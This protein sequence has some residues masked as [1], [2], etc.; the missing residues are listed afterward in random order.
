MSVASGAADDVD[1]CGKKIPQH[2]AQEIELLRA[3]T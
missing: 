2:G 1:A 3:L